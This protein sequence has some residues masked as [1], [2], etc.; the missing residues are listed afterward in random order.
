MQLDDF[1]QLDQPTQWQTIMA[2]S[3]KMMDVSRDA[4]WEQ[5]QNMDALRRQLMECF[6]AI[7]PQGEF[8]EQVGRDIQSILDAD[9]A[10][11]ELLKAARD[12]IPQQMNK[13]NQGRKATNAYNENS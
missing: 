10:I 7:Q 3:A 5:L 13:L 6:F 8:A 12:V 2:F 11:V 4:N 9:K 1:K